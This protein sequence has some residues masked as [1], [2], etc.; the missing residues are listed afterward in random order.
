[1][2]VIQPT[3]SRGGG[4]TSTLVCRTGAVECIERGEMG[5]GPGHPP[6]LYMKVDV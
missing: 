2:L 1:M 3:G 6:V 4:V 5:G